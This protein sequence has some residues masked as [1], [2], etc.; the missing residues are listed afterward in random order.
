MIDLNGFR[1]FVEVVDRGGF[2]AAA[3]ALQQPT[4]TMSYRIQQLEREL[5][6][7]LLTRTSRRVVMTN[8]GE[9]FYGYA[10]ATIQHADEAEGIMRDRS[11]E[12]VGTVHFTVS[13]AIAQY[14]MTDML[15][16][17]LRK[18]PKVNLIQSAVDEV[19]DI[20]GNRY[21]LAIRE[22]SG[23]LPDSQLVQRSL[24]TVPWQMFATPAYLDRT[25][26]PETPIDLEKSETLFKKRG[27]ADPVLDLRAEH[28]ASRISR[29][30]LSPRIISSSAVTLKH[31]AAAD[32]GIV[33]LPAYLCRDELASGKF[34]RVLP[35]W[36]APDSTVTAL[37]PDRRGITAATRVFVEHV[38]QSFPSAV[39]TDS[40]VPTGGDAD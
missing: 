35:G 1:Y 22:H 40:E 29:I 39:S 14:A 16:S 18:F 5:G 3:R 13:T 32:M 9:E 11:V 26:R 17:F 7:T 27:S 12:P 23:P 34:E 10:K 30:K 19:V 2:A 6:L 24:A 33:A 8:A 36:A 28:D 37:I 20:L 15:V 38:A 25:F 31:A 21:D 4:S